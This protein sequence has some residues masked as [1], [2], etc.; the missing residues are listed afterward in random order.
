M[1]FRISNLCSGGED[2]RRSSLRNKEQRF[3]RVSAR[4]TPT[5]QASEK[6]WNE[7]V[8][9]RPKASFCNFR[10]W[11]H[12]VQFAQWMKCSL[13]DRLSKGK[14]VFPIHVDMWMSTT[15]MKHCSHDFTVVC[16]SGPLQVGFEDGLLNA[17]VHGWVGM[18]GVENIIERQVVLH[19]Q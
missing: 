16:G 11:F 15:Q 18:D 9:L 17:T 4:G 5:I 2:F 13:L 6:Q 10:L 7:N 8:H 19:G 12:L 14:G 1:R 3:G